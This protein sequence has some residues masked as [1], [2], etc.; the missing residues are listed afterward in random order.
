MLCEGLCEGLPTPHGF[1]TEGLRFWIHYYGWL[2]TCGRRDGSVGRPAKTWM[3]DRPQ[4]EKEGTGQVKKPVLRLGA[5]DWKRDHVGDLVCAGGEHDE[6]VEAE[7]YAGT[8][9]EA[10]VHGGE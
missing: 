10:V 1:S 2:E 3:S 4:P 6:A 7:G 8:R 5:I 9:W